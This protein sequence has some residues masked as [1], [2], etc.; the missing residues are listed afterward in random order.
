MPGLTAG[1]AG[2]V[3][4]A[5]AAGVEAE[6]AEKAGGTAAVEGLTV[7]E[8]EGEGNALGPSVRATTTA[9]ETAGEELCCGLGPWAGG[10]RGRRR[11][12]AH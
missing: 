11:F 12:S 3:P 5:E 6:A 8:V 9:A 4:A 1:P 2:K 10:G 7:E